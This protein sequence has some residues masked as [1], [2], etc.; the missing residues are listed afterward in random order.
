MLIGFEWD[1]AKAKANVRKHGV[2]F[3]EACTSFDDILSQTI[4]DPDHSE[5]E[6]RFTTLGLSKR[7]NLLVVCHCDR[8]DNIRIISAR[9]AND[10]ERKQYENA[11]LGHQ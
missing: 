4:D 1:P 7:G 3:D 2:S 11:N 8:S 10:C 5:D 9:H 6:F